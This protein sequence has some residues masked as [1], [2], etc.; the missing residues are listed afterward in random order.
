MEQREGADSTFVINWS[1]SEG[2]GEAINLNL[3]DSKRS[4]HVKPVEAF[5]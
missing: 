1:I 3:T 4:L 5:E 2:E